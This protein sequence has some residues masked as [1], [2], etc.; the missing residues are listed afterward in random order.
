MRTA[1]GCPFGPAHGDAPGKPTEF[2]DT[3]RITEHYGSGGRGDLEGDPAPVTDGTR[4]HAPW[5]R[6]STTCPSRRPRSPS[7]LRRAR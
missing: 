3:A 1:S 6:A 2:W 5:P 4:R 7:E